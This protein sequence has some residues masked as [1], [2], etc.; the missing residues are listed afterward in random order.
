MLDCF[1]AQSN[2]GFC[3]LAVGVGHTQPLRGFC[4]PLS[5]VGRLTPCGVTWFLQL[6]CFA[7]STKEG[8]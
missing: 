6:D 8:L 4:F 3:S 1:A 2:E 5:A 7:A